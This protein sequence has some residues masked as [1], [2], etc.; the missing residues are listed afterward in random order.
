MNAFVA[1][2]ETEDDV[3]SEVAH[4]VVV[5][6]Q[7]VVGRIAAYGD[8]GGVEGCLAAAFLVAGDELLAVEVAVAFPVGGSLPVGDGRAEDRDAV[9]V[10]G[11]VDVV[12]HLVHVDRDGIG[13]GVLIDVLRALTLLRL[14][15]VVACGSA[16]EPLDGKGVIVVQGKV[17]GLVHPLLRSRL[18]QG[19]FSLEHACTLVGDG[20][21][22]CGDAA[23]DV[24]RDGHDGDG[25]GGGVDRDAGHAVVCHVEGLVARRSEGAV[26][27]VVEADGLAVGLSGEGEGACIQARIYLI[28]IVAKHLEG[29][30]LGIAAKL[31]AGEDERFFGSDAALVFLHPHGADV[32][33]AHES[34][35]GDEDVAALV[36]VDIVAAEYVAEVAVVAFA[37]DARAGCGLTALPRALSGYGVEGAT[38]GID[39]ARAV[40][41]EAV[42]MVGVELSQA[43]G[44]CVAVVD[45][46]VVLG[47]RL[48]GKVAQVVHRGVVVA[49]SLDAVA[50]SLV[51]DDEACAGAGVRLVL[52]GKRLVGRNGITRTAARVDVVPVVAVRVLSCRGMAAG[53]VVDFAEVEV[54]LLHEAELLVRAFEAGHFLYLHAIEVD[55]DARSLLAYRQGD[56]ACTVG[57]DVV[58][59]Q[60]FVVVAVVPAGADTGARHDH[61]PLPVVHA[62][63]LKVGCPGV[64]CRARAEEVE[65]VGAARVESLEVDDAVVLSAFQEDVVLRGALDGE[66][67][68][69]GCRRTL[70][71]AV[72]IAVGGEAR[73][74]LQAKL[75]LCVVG[76]HEADGLRIGLVGCSRAFAEDVVPVVFVLVGTRCLV[77]LAGD[78]VLTI[79]DVER[80]F[81]HLRPGCQHD[82]QPDVQEKHFYP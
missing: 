31:E 24:H 55:H 3:T 4:E 10:D 12:L 18:R 15:Q 74:E 34:L 69:E 47:G 14:S 45:E 82:G 38:V 26:A 37:S 77:P 5:A 36:R 20:G 35:H 25:G 29:G 64:G 78:I 42:A 16:P 21:I 63:Q 17:H 81:L 7:Q 54:H 13:A 48:D 59:G 75:S 61:L 60:D 66:V 53:I 70:Q 8:V 73:R 23:T 52:D 72:R 76:R 44:P 65:T 19:D 32:G 30:V 79:V 9:L 1:E 71:A 27:V 49:A 57:E 51:H 43:E 50:V 40:D 28:Y 6:V 67:A 58:G 56:V 46:D 33:H 2:R 11:C 39:V 22:A 62:A 68:Q 80:A 41:V